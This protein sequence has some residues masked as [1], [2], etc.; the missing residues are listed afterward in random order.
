MITHA[1]QSPLLTYYRAKYL[2]P[3]LNRNPVLHGRDGFKNSVSIQLSC[4]IN[5][6]AQL[7]ECARYS[8]VQYFNGLMNLLVEFNAFTLCGWSE[9]QK[10]H[11]L[12]LVCAISFTRRTRRR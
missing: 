6:I 11:C 8:R 7:T 10:S 4:I 12:R 1:P 9:F 5:E 2:T 3:Y